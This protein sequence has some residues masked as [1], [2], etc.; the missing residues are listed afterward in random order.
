MMFQVNQDNKQNFIYFH[1]RPLYMSLSISLVYDSLRSLH[2]MQR[3]L[4]RHFMSSQMHTS[5]YYTDDHD[6]E[7]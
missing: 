3:I 4:C 7:K 5:L 2:A 1:V 6:N